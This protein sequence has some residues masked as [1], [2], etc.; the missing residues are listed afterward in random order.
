MR[1]ARRRAEMPLHGPMP[2]CGVTNWFMAN[3]RLSKL[4]RNEKFQGAHGGYEFKRSKDCSNLDKKSHLIL[5]VMFTPH[6]RLNYHLFIDYVRIVIKPSTT[7]IASG[8]CD[9]RL[10]YLGEC[11]IRDTRDTLGSEEYN[12]IPV[13][14]S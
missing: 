2:F 10:R 3:T 12:K 7:G 6:Y 9:S 8:L 1:L 4:T 14:Y 13:G 5:I 11:F